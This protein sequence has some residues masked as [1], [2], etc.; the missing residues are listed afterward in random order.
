[1]ITV[2]SASTLAFISGSS[3]R[4]DGIVGV[5]LG[6]VKATAR[7][8]VSGGTP[9]LRLATAFRHPSA[10][11]LLREGVDDPYDLGVVVGVGGPLAGEVLEVGAAAALDPPEAG[12][13]EAA[14]Q[15][16]AAGVGLE[17]L[18]LGADADQGLRLSA[19]PAVSPGPLSVEPAWSQSHSRRSRGSGY[20]IHGPGRDENQ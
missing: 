17:M 4:H 14:M 13:D 2:I 20:G 12:V 8:V 1:L 6:V 9:N 18:D 3:R 7:G 10:L 15:A 11:G 5:C 16:F 19:R